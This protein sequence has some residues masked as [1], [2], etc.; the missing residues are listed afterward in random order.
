[1]K[2]DSTD[3]TRQ[4]NMKIVSLALLFTAANAF[5][6]G[7]QT[8]VSSI[9]RT[10]STTVLNLFG[11]KK[12]GNDASITGPGFMDQMAM[13][14]KAQ[15][16]AQ[17]K[18]KLDEELQKEEFSGQAADGKVKAMLKFVPVKNPMDPNPDYEATKFEFDDDFYA[19]A[20][21]EELSKAVTDA[22]IDGIASTNQKVAEKYAVLQQ[23]L[24]EAMGGGPKPAQ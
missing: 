3:H 12:E 4:A 1:M 24:M 15:E 23:D 14:K 17:K 20:S 6:V 13:F 22:L 16:M 5:S 2:S 7:T 10:T 19:S 21:P 8:S 11:G 18:Q 9:S